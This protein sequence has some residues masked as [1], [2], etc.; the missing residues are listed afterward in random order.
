MVFVNF[1]KRIRRG[2][3]MV[4]LLLTLLP[5]FTAGLY[6]EMPSDGRF[7]AIVN[8]PLTN[9]KFDD[10]YIQFVA[11][12]WLQIKEQKASMPAVL[13]GSISKGESDYILGAGDTL[14]VVIPYLYNST[15]RNLTLRQ[16]Q[17]RIFEDPPESIDAVIRANGK[18]TIPPFGTFTVSGMT[19]TEFNQMLTEMAKLYLIEPRV[20]VSIKSMRPY[21]VYITGEVQRPGGYQ[22]LNAPEAAY[23]SFADN[24]STDA[25]T[26]H[27][28]EPRISSM[29]VKAGGI[30]PYA[31]V[32]NVS[33]T[34]TRTG[35]NIVVNLEDIVAKGDTSQDYVLQPD[36][37]I[38]VPP[39][40]TQVAPELLASVIGSE[41]VIV[42]VFGYM[43]KGGSGNTDVRL[44]PRSMT[45][46]NALSHVN[47]DPEADL[48]HLYVLRKREDGNTFEKFTFN[49]LERDFPLQPNDVVVV[50]HRRRIHEIQQLLTAAS[51][52]LFAGFSG[53]NIFRQ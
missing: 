15:N 44:D 2:V 21:T 50:P 18:A 30:L 52:L 22:T 49:G 37:V 17:T 42:R 48:R 19:V 47:T 51:T 26:Q 27:F 12:K 39:S 38:H 35:K 41:T 31:D 24:A 1:S 3:A 36:D 23:L 25:K 4:T 45:A 6:A 53:V 8:R 46:L 14:T 11:N 32:Q 29:I 40:K 16:Q 28:Y 7:Q 20:Y 43:N 13:K 34:N 9:D 33:V 10:D 5:M